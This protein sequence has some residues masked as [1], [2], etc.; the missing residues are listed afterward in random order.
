MSTDNFGPSGEPFGDPDVD[1]EMK[2]LRGRYEDIYLQDT[3]FSKRV[4]DANVY[5]ISG[6]RGTGK[7]ALSRYFTF[8]NQMP[9]IRHIEVRQRE[10]YPQVLTSIAELLSRSPVAA[11]PQLVKVWELVTWTVI[12]EALQNDV[13]VSPAIE[14]I[15][16][17]RSPSSFL[18]NALNWVY[19]SLQNSTPE[20]T[21][22]QINEL[23]DAKT[24]ASGIDKVKAFAGRSQQQIVISIDTLE[25][26][27]TEDSALMMAVAALIQFASTFN[28]DHSPAVQVKVFLPGEIYGHLEEAVILAPAKHLR[29]PLHLIWSPSDLVRL[30]MWR[31]WRYLFKS[32]ASVRHKVPDVRWSDS[33]EVYQKMWRRYFDKTVSGPSGTENALVYILRHTQMRPRQLI[34]VCNAIAKAAGSNSADSLKFDSAHIVAGVAAAQ[35]RLVADVINSFILTYHYVAEIMEVLSGAPAVLTETE[36]A[37]YAEKSRTYWQAGTYS[38]DRFRKLLADLGIIGRIVGRRGRNPEVIEAEFDYSTPD[39]LVIGRNEDCVIH[40]MFHRRLNI[41]SPKVPRILPFGPH[42]PDL[43]RITG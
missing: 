30:I 13:S 14:T 39:K 4:F 7:T 18:T 24:V 27:D 16:E 40:P 34:L 38:P 17:D 33:R 5:L 11:I 42:L 20:K 41:A 23:V 21:A 6:R 28:L 8:Q 22:S 12:F 25:M 15:N 1:T 36:L 3:Q 9:G 29:D 43:E 37:R 19:R 35:G 2:R 26:Y 10:A 31:F 32:F